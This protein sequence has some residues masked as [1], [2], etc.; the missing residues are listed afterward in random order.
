MVVVVG[1]ACGRMVRATRKGERGSWGA[2]REK[3]RVGGGGRGADAFEEGGPAGQFAA[4]FSQQRE[5]GKGVAPA[6]VAG[7]RGRGGRVGGGGG[8]GGQ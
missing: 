4:S 2:S 5:A 7:A 1:L 8:A 6:V 3:G